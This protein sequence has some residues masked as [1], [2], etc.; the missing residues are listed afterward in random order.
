MPN[1]VA[2]LRAIN[3]IGRSIEMPVLAEHFCSIG[4]R[5]VQTSID[6]GNVLF[7]SSS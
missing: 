2:F 6:T 3:V 4:Y 7:H 1:Y 5:A